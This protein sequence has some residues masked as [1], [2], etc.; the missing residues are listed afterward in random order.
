MSSSEGYSDD[1][2]LIRY[3]KG[4]Q[5]A[6][7]FSKVDIS[8]IPIDLLSTINKSKVDSYLQIA[9]NRK[10]GSSLPNGLE[11]LLA[12]QDR[13][14]SLSAL[15]NFNLSRFNEADVKVEEDME[16]RLRSIFKSLDLNGNDKVDLVD[17]STGVRVMGLTQM[18]EQEIADLFMDFG[19]GEDQDDDIHIE[20][21]LAALQNEKTDRIRKF[22]AM[23]LNNKP[24]DGLGSTGS[25]KEHITKLEKIVDE[26]KHKNLRLEVEKNQLQ[27]TSQ[28]L[29]ADRDKKIDMLE[30]HID[31]LQKNAELSRT[32]Y[33]SD[34][35]KMSELRGLQVGRAWNDG[36]GRKSSS[37]QREI[38][39]LK[40]ELSKLRIKSLIDEKELNE[41]LMQET[42]RANKYKIKYENLKLQI[43]GQKLPLGSFRQK[44]SSTEDELDKR[45]RTQKVNIKQNTKQSLAIT[46]QKQQ[47]LR[48]SKAGKIS[49]TAAKVGESTVKQGDPSEPFFWRQK[50]AIGK[51]GKPKCAT[52]WKFLSSDG[53]SHNLQLVHTQTPTESVDARRIVRV[54]GQE[55]YNRKSSACNFHLQINSEPLCVKLIWE[56]GGTWD[57]Q[58]FINNENFNEQRKRY[59]LLQ[60]ITEMT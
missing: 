39:S 57:Y 13:R 51:S 11:E 55:Q 48:S 56:K 49:R 53:K 3:D 37:P 18:G 24:A 40:D 45:P 26:L 38:Q 8:K 7:D 43:V 22:K 31:V 47:L 25:D 10:G 28:S 44:P 17:F 29:L 52:Y 16:K 33:E 1:G 60:K 15:E 19:D 2:M 41:K 34:L 5:A 58:L 23:Y 20:T 21:L 59:L 12:N 14:K 30:R 42:N 35:N 27:A 54:D 50:L 6:V 4:P 36:N 32:Q 9:H 46:R